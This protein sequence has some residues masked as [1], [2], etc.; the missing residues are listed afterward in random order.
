M[1]RAPATEYGREICGGESGRGAAT[2][3]HERGDRRGGDEL[4]RPVALAR[5]SSA[6][7]APR[8]EGAAP[9]A[10]PAPRAWA[11]PSPLPVATAP[12]PACLQDFGRLEATSATPVESDREAKLHQWLRVSSEGR[13]R[14][15]HAVL[16]VAFAAA[17]TSAAVTANPPA[18]LSADVV[19]SD[20]FIS[21]Q[22]L[23]TAKAPLVTL[24]STQLTVSSY[25][26][27][28]I[29]AGLPAGTPPGSYALV[30][31]SYGTPAGVA[32]VPAGFVLTQ[33]TTGAAGPTG[34]QGPAGSMGAT[35]P[36]GPSG[37][38]GPTGPQGPQGVQGPI[39]A[40]GP[41]GQSV[42]GA[43]EGPGQN[44][45]YGGVSFTSAGVTTYAC[46]GAPGAP[47]PDGA[48]GSPGPIGAT[49]D[50][51]PAGPG[52]THATPLYLIPPGS[53]CIWGNFSTLSGPAFPLV[54]TKSD[55]EY[56]ACTGGDTSPSCGGNCTATGDVWGQQECDQ[57]GICFYIQLC[58]PCSC[59]NT[60]IGF[61]VQ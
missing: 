10:V 5:A 6:S 16:S 24:G 9:R 17:T 57:G 53:R 4:E 41:A 1:K 47:G 26:P 25:A 37:S 11:R 54:T 45:P 52:A 31:Q 33:G 56:T 7:L 51:G 39:G 44:C 48:Q 55:C 22:N 21:G 19:G 29:V 35:G 42:V 23:G 36:Q 3:I 32:L 46:N 38:Q 50:V 30:V 15:F 14:M 59:T 34:P 20:V 40:I 2:C 60:P 12:S 61:A 18:V 8:P 13:H 27:T 43:S 58:V 49:G 28:S